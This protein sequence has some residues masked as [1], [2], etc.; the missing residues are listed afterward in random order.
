ML[1]SLLPSFSACLLLSF[2]LAVSVPFEIIITNID[3]FNYGIFFHVRLSLTIFLLINAS[4]FVFC[5]ALFYIYKPALHLVESLLVSCVVIFLLNSAFLFGEYGA[6]DGRG[7]RIEALS[8]LSLLQLL[9]ALVVF[10]TVLVREEILFLFLKIGFAFTAITFFT[11]VVLFFN[12]GDY[13]SKHPSPISEKYF[14]FSNTEPNYLYVL[15][16]EVYGGSAKEIFKSNEPFVESYQGFTFFTDVAG[17]YPTT[18]MSIPAVLNKS[19]YKNTQPVS[20]FIKDSFSNSKLLNTLKTKGYPSFVHSSGMYCNKTKVENCSVMGS[21]NPNQKTAD[22]EYGRAFDLAVFKAVPDIL[23]SAIY[24]KGNWLFEKMVVQAGSE[25]RGSFQVKEFNYFINELNTNADSS[26]FKFY[27]NTVTHSPVRHDESCDLLQENKKS[28]YKNYLPQDACGFFLVAKLV[29]KLKALG[30][31]DNTYIVVSSDHGRPFVPSSYKEAFEEGHSGATSRQYGYAHAMLLVKPFKADGEIKFS[32]NPTSL[33]GISDL[34]IASIKSGI[35]SE[36]E[37]AQLLLP[38]GERPFYYYD[39]T[40][41]YHDWQQESLPPFK[42]IYEISKNISDPASWEE[43]ADSFRDIVVSNPQHSLTCGKE[44]NFSDQQDLSLY[45]PHG[46]SNIEPWG[47]WSDG[48]IVKLYF[49]GNESPCANHRV[50]LKLN[51][52]LKEVK[53]SQHAEVFL[54]GVSI[55]NVEFKYGG[56]TQ[57][58]FSFKYLTEI[59]K[60]NETN[61]IELHIDNPLSPKRLGLGDDKR[62]LAIGFVSMRME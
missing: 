37:D 22:K 40:V 29:D 46:L 62:K 30:V 14:Q 52:Y 33:L 35:T 23:K 55:G 9:I 19:L 21:M 44:I 48:Q 1:K 12:E 39:W 6:F 54:N 25:S 59:Y 53:P 10:I 60:A 5:V 41:D 17:V 51:A 8:M 13:I 26:S 36:G 2:I 49:K 57:K 47:R 50:N 24:N 27:H 58:V 38:R 11:N 45:S 61:L 43:G 4:L 31:Y 20:G 34:F 32:N 16:D 42:G 3:E 18:I 7:L 56:D 28:E 15:L